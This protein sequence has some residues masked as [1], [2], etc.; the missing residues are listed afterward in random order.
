MGP[1]LY[2]W[3][4]PQKHSTFATDRL[5]VVTVRIEQEGGVIARRITLGDA[6]QTGRTVIS[7]T[8]LKSGGVK[9]VY[10]SSIPGGEGSVLLNSMW[11]EAVNPEYRMVD[12]IADAVGPFV[13]G[14]LHN[15]AQAERA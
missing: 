14:Q 11:V 2:L 1:R 3:E 12:A 6:A 8:S 5:D 13:L 4:I 10:G 15:P 9:G 7:P